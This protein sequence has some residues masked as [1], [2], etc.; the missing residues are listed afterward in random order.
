MSPPVSGGVRTDDEGKFRLEGLVP[1]GEYYLMASKYLP[2]VGDFIGVGYLT[3]PVTIRSGETK[4]LGDVQVRRG[5]PPS[6]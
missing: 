5:A 4:D 2:Q 1:G 6:Q 3:G